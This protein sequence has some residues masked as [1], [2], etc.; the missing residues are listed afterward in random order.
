MITFRIIK[1]WGDGRVAVD[2]RKFVFTV[3]LFLAYLLTAFRTVHSEYTVKILL[4]NESGSTLNNVSLGGSGLSAYY[5]SVEAGGIR[6]IL[7]EKQTAIHFNV[8]YQGPHGLSPIWESPSFT[9]S[10]PTEILVIINKDEQ[11]EFQ[12]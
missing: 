3:V 11:V 12:Y 2:N 10:P 4:L 5:L 9:D 6:S 8:D 1:F 7:L